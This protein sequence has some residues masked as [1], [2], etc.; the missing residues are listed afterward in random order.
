VLVTGIFAL[1]K[2]FGPNTGS[3][4]QGQYLYIH[5]GSSY[6]DV[7]QTL[8]EGGYINDIWSFDVLAG[9]AKYPARVHPGKYK[10]EKGMSNY[11]MLRML[12]NGSQTPVKLVIN[13]LR[14]KKDLSSLLGKHLE[15]DSV[16][17]LR[18]LNDPSFAANYDLDTNTI[19]CAV[20]QDTYI[21]LWNT[22]AD[23]AFKKIAKNYEHFWTDERL[24]QA[25]DH[26][27]SKTQV[28]AL[29]SIVDEESNKNDE[30]PN[31][32]STYIN[33]VH[34]GMLLQADPTV[35]FAIGDFM[36]R[37][38]T[39]AYLKVNSPYNTYVSKGLP[40]GP[41][42]TPSV[43]SIDA[44]LTAPQTKYLYFCARP[45]FSGYHNFTASYNEQV[46]NAHLYQQ[47]LDE[48]NIH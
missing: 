27:L 14:T 26:G 29:A 25:K 46:K 23:K 40:P 15:E 34:K 32:A 13:K 17:A 19:M 33:R 1:Y 35:K 20:M 8:K 9:F 2:T 28:I 43:S 11:N 12:R 48:K 37:R 30:K 6:E 31:I 3:L 24:Q 16:A 39:G 44:V 22:P 21:F 7:K 45:D 5:T 10:I 47:A 42:C 41:I 18:M 36:I 4:Q 38:I